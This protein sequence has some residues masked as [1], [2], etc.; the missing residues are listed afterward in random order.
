MFNTYFLLKLQDTKEEKQQI[1]REKLR[2]VI[3]N[4]NM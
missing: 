2:G 4:E 1:E 3:H